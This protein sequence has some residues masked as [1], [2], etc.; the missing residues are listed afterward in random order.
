VTRKRR[1]SRGR[2]LLSRRALLTL[3]GTGAVGIGSVYGTGAFSRV[4]GD[5]TVDVDPASDDEALL[6]VDIRDPS[7][8]S[9]ERVTLLELT[10]Q[11]A[12]PVETVTASVDGAS[13]AP[14]DVSGLRTPDRLAVGESGEITAPLSCGSDASGNADV[15]VTASGPDTSVTLTRS[16]PVACRAPTG[17]CDPRLIPSGCTVDAIPSGGKKSTDCSVVIERDGEYESENEAGVDIGGALDITA[18]ESISLSTSGNT[19]I[20]DY[21]R[22]NTSGEVE[23]EISGTPT[24]GG[25]IQVDAGSSSVT[26]TG[27]ASANGGLCVKSDGETE[28]EITG[29]ATIDGDLEVESG[30]G[31]DA[32]V[33]LSGNATVTGD[34]SAQSDGDGEIEIEGCS[35][36]QGTV[37]PQT[38][39]SGG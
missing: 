14:V 24:V 10:N 12:E 4:A 9:G 22:L 7:G 38:A 2:S 17:V 26:I 34:L 25:P 23:V 1:R 5:R 39:C 21:L 13:N 6:G 35:R 3:L 37:S 8:R 15:S 32:S 20:S 30:S 29:N 33:S 36:V 31:E 19:A 16:V 28:V 11:F 18:T 27:N